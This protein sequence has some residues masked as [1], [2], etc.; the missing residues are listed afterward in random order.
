LE[1]VK[2]KGNSPFKNDAPF[3]EVD[4]TILRWDPRESTNPLIGSVHDPIYQGARRELAE[5]G[6]PEPKPG[7][8]SEAHGGILFIDE[9]GE[10]E[11]FLQNKLLKVLEDKRVY[12]ESSYYDPN[13]ARVPKYIKKIFEE[14][15]PADFVLIGA[16]TRDR[17]DI[18]PHFVR[19]VWRFIFSRS[20]RSILKNR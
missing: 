16:T 20:D 14:G 4:G 11:P 9:I 12:F 15:I 1:I 10:M 7:L 19:V 5:D 13:N 18:T 2:T 17:S 6:I 3:I 8:V